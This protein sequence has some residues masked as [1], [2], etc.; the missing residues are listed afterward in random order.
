LEAQLE[1]ELDGLEE[2][3]GPLS[4]STRVAPPV[5]VGAASAA[6]D[7]EAAVPAP[8]AEGAAAAAMLAQRR[9]ALAAWLVRARNGTLDGKYMFLSSFPICTS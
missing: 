1:L 7:G 9:A 6:A 4:L 3:F 5:S 8:V 2:D